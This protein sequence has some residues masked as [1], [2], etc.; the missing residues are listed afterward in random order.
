MYFDGVS[1]SGIPMDPNAYAQHYALENG[2][3][4]DEAKAQLKSRYGD[5]I[6]PSLFNVKGKEAQTNTF[7]AL[8][9]N[10]EKLAAYIKKGAK[11]TGMNEKEFAAMMGLPPKEE[12]ST[13]DAKKLEE[14]RKLG[15]PKEV[16]EKGDDA[17]RK[18][19]QTHNIN[20]PPKEKR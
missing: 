3:S 2:I 8:T 9:D 19:A 18:Y 6:P 13:E 17:I 20:L 7:G 14:L 12:K 16:I 15:I 5:P 4:L 11:E 1:G 10:P